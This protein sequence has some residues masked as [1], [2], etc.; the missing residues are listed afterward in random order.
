M[1]GDKLSEPT[2]DV[3]GNFTQGDISGQSAIGNNISQVQYTN[4]TFVYPDG[5]VRHGHSWTYTQGFRP[6]IDQKKIFG[7]END[8]EILE[9]LFKDNSAVVIKGFCGTGKSILASMFIDRMEKKG[10]FVGIYWRKINETTDIEDIIGSFFTA[11]GK[12]VKDLV[13]YKIPDQISILFRELNEGSY[14]IVLDN[15]ESLLDPQTNKPL[16]SKVG[17][18]ELI[19]SAAANCIRSKILF[20][21]WESLASER[22]ISPF[23]YQIKGLDASAGILLLRHQG[24]LNESEVELKKAIEMS[25]GHPLALILLAQLVTKGADTLSSLLKDNSLWIRKDGEIAENILNKVYNERLSE[26]ERKLLQYVSIFRQPV[27]AK[28]ITMIANGPVITELNS[29]KVIWKLCLNYFNLFFRDPINARPT[30]IA[31]DDY[32]W[33]E[34]KVEKTTWNLYLKSLLQKNGE[35]CWEESLISKYA[36]SQLSAKTE[37]Y[38][39]AMEYYLSLPIPDKPAEKEDIQPLIEAHY[40][41]CM[42]GEYDQA[43]HIIFD[44]NLPEYLDFLGNYVLLADIYSKLL[45]EDH[46]GKDT[47]LKDKKSHSAI[48]GNL[49]AVY[50][51]LGEYT[52]AIEYLKQAQIIDKGSWYRPRKG[53]WLG[54]LGIAYYRLGEY[55]KAIEYYKRALKFDRKVRDKRGEVI[56]LGNL[57]NVYCD[58][59][60]YTKAIEYY[61]QALKIARKIGYKRG[62]GSWLG[63]LGIAYTHLGEYTKAIEY[64]E[65]ALKIARKIGN[66]REEEIDL[67][68]L[69]NVYCDLGEYTKAIEYYEQALKIAR[70]IGDRRGEGNQLGNLGNAYK[71]LGDPGKAIEYCEQALFVGREIKDPRIINLCERELEEFEKFKKINFNNH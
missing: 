17:F 33:S 47:L 48:L 4:C 61:E 63:N 15:F 39:F 44:N 64:C 34:Y 3:G 30:I 37:R 24:L 41:A 5:S 22:G 36:A 71:D 12:P 53:A 46:F 1:T 9:D 13:G 31:A 7:R 54:N 57:G 45:P 28:A 25:D 52:K 67:E 65:Q 55:T 27:P 42:A 19:E 2:I 35:K 26:D 60:E 10:K 29:K 18:S 6:I 62:E 43:L 16:K 68:N 70:K 58:L 69:G 66:R 40:Y 8:L 21:S 51:Y 14:L 11:I 32:V 59:G 20:T 56:C 50:T 49:G 23:S 38:R